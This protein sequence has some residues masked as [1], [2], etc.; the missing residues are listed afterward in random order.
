MTRELARAPQAPPDVAV[1][2]EPVAAESGAVAD[3]F[4]KLMPTRRVARDK[5]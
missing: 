4:T 1:S 3:V 2:C 5:V